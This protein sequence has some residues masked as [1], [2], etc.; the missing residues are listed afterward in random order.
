M[1]LTSAENTTG[2]KMKKINLSDLM[3]KL[4]SASMIP[5][6]LSG[7]ASY[8]LSDKNPQYM[9]TKHAEA[10]KG[11]CGII[12]FEYV[13]IDIDDAKLMSKTDLEKWNEL[14]LN[15]VN[16]A[17]ICGRT[18]RVASSKSIPK[19]V[20]YIIDGKV[21]SFYF[22]KN[23]VPMFFP[24]WVGLTF[25]TLGV[26]GIAAGPTTS[27]KV[28]F[29]FTA[30]LKN[31]QTGQIYESIPERFESTDVMTIYSDDNDNP[32]GNPGLAFDSTINGATKKLQEAIIKTRPKES[33][34]G[35][36]GAIKSL[37]QLL[38]SGVLTMPEYLNK[39]NSLHDSDQIK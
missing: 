5:V 30:N 13:P 11:V 7:C 14:F 26:Y 37:K 29:G 35:K 32:Y 28:D 17:D 38:D 33:D 31:P 22:K 8:R 9:V 3:H 19:N 15:A 6:F 10:T 18:I 39:I 21:T 12:P 34:L 27:T 20:D 23:W 4:V 24:G 36:N 25:F 2:C 16:T 1:M